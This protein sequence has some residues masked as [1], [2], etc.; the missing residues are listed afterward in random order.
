MVKPFNISVMQVYA[1]ISSPADEE[2][3][4]FYRDLEK[5]IKEVPKK[6]IA[7]QGDWNAKIGTDARHQW[8]RTDGKYG[9]GRG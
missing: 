8:K 5:T 7:P 9:V 4:D 6:D 1:L 2:I 3:E